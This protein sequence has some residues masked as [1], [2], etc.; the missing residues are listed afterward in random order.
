MNF[1]NI[2]EIKQY[3]NNNGFFYSKNGAVIKPNI[4]TGEAL[5]DI[6]QLLPIE[7]A[8][9]QEIIINNIVNPLI[10]VEDINLRRLATIIDYRPINYYEKR[11]KEN[12][13]L[14]ETHKLL[15]DC[16]FIYIKDTG[17]Y[18]KIQNSKVRKS[19]IFTI[20]KELIPEEEDIKAFDN[21][22]TVKKAFHYK[23]SNNKNK[24]AYEMEYN[25]FKSLDI[26]KW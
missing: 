5:S 25:K 24:E 16:K 8:R 21:Y 10:L 19:G 26:C 4:K 2:K 22:N 9:L 12:Q 1:N 15:K 3:L 13:K 20:S 23:R 18:Y 7:E 17:K 6:H 11:E 14:K